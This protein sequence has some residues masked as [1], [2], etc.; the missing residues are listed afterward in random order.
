M[1]KTI[2]RAKPTVAPGLNPGPQM[3]LLLAEAGLQKSAPIILQASA[4]RYRARK[5]LQAKLLYLA[6]PGWKFTLDKLHRCM[7]Y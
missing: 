5:Y 4:G 1:V 7:K 6:A 3:T 2:F